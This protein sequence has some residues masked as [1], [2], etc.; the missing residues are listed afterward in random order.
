MPAVALAERRV[1]RPAEGGDRQVAN[2]NNGHGEPGQG[3]QP[4]CQ[5]P[6]HPEVF[7]ETALKVLPSTLF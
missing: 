1:E 6:W 2:L 3:V 5:D 7:S 4:G